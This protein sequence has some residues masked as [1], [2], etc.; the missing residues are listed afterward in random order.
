MAEPTGLDIVIAHRGATRWKLRTTGR[1]CHSSRPQDGINA[2][3][4]MAQVIGR[5]EE[6]AEKLPELV[7][8]HPLCG[9]P[10]MSIGRIEGGIS[11]NTVPDV[12]E[13]EIDR[14]VIPGE[15]GSYPY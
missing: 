11:V 3:Y 8:A 15:D 5:L 12:C 2:I 1:A 7:P 13:I 4:R 14:R 9:P 10:T 6:Y